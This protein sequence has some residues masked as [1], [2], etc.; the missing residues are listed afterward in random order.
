MNVT[1]RFLAETT[2]MSSHK[3]LKVLGVVLALSAI[4]WAVPTYAGVIGYYSYDNPNDLGADESGNAY[5]GVVV[6]DVTAAAGVSGGAAKFG[7]ATGNF[8]DLPVG[9][10]KADGNIPTSNFTLAAFF[11]VVYKDPS[12]NPLYAHGQHAI[13]NPRAGDDTY[14]LHPEIR[15]TDYRFTLRDYGMTAIGDIRPAGAV[16]DEWHH[17][18]MTWDRAATRMAIYIDGDLLM[19]KTD[20]ADRNM[21]ADWDDGARIGL[22]IDNARQYTGLM[23]ELY[24][25]N[26]TLSDDAIKALANVPEPSSIVLALGATLSVLLLRRKWNS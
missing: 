21:A 2:T 12:Q 24:L 26:E 19:E 14:L 11:N 20:C 6:G 9:D 10:I 18:A 3:L 15:Q 17:I 16:F 4:M 13:F 8:I 1:P 7:A 5:H 22:N 23:D 25:F